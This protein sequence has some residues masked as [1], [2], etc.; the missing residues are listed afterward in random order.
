VKF[1]DTYIFTCS[2]AQHDDYNHQKSNTNWINIERYLNATKL[3]KGSK[4]QRRETIN[5]NLPSSSMSLIEYSSSS[6]QLFI[7]WPLICTPGRCSNTLAR[8]GVAKERHLWRVSDPN[9]TRNTYHNIFQSLLARAFLLRTGWQL[10]EHE[11][12]DE[13]RSQTK[14][15]EHEQSAGL[16]SWNGTGSEL[17]RALKDHTEV[18]SPPWR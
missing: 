3:S 6:M 16:R 9:K 4:Y 1:E 5:E 2:T 12:S 10:G 7:C 14:K 11:Q 17:N 15:M 8:W 13:K 18:S